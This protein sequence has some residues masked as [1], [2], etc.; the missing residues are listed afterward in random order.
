MELKYFSLS[1]TENNRLVKFIR[2]VFGILCI[3]VA[4]FWLSF[5]IK[6]LKTD[7]TLWITIVFLSGFG[8]YQIWSGMGRATTY[9]EIGPDCIR[10]KKNPILAFIEMPALEIE[11]IEL[12]PMSVVFFF[13]IKKKNT[14]PVRFH[15]LCNK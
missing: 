3:A 9:I 11:K 15:L 7:A 10:L 13:K 5:N 2:I 14:A 1:T 4:T 8:F 6:L 12:F